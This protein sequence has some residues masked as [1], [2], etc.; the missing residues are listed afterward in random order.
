MQ[1]EADHKQADFLRHTDKPNLYF[2]A[3]M[4]GMMNEC[5]PKP[6]RYAALSQ[7]LHW[8][9]ALGLIVAF[10][11]GAVMTDI[12][13][14]SPLKL[15]LYNWH[16][17]LGVVLWALCLLRWVWRFVKRPPAPPQGM[18]ALQKNMATGMHYLLY[19][20]MFTVPLTGYF[21]SLAAGY[22]VVLF[23]MIELPVLIPKTLDWA[24]PL[25]E[26]HEI[27]TKVLL[28]LT[29]MHVAAALWHQWI[30]RDGLIWRI[31]PDWMQRR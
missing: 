2:T 23:G 24:E 25:K 1:I 20:A 5:T 6:L 18:S 19:M 10:V 3:Y 7:F 9:M 14:I 28:G 8:F 4:P 15:K 22:P 30:L 29:G 31:L 13:G 21:Y 12:K 16:K 27:S 11:M 26:I 17:W